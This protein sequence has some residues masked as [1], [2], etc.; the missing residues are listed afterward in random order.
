MQA[1]CSLMQG[2]VDV[3]TWQN[4]ATANLLDRGL[5]QYSDVAHTL[6]DSVYEFEGI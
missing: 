2:I 4:L 5:A 6:V 3:V 1:S